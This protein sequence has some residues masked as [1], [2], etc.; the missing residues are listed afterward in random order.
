MKVRTRFIK[1]VIATANATKTE[2]PW[3]R[4]TTRR[5]NALRRTEPT[6]ALRTARSA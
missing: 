2:L 1:S 3:A 5:A 4:G 6:P